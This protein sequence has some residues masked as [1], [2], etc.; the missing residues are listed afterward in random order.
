MIQNIR[1][2]VK[3]SKTKGLLGSDH[4][5]RKTL[6]FLHKLK[7]VENHELEPFNECMN[8]VISACSLLR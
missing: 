1:K 5:L 2:I 8:L 6:S 7:M 4:S 3:N